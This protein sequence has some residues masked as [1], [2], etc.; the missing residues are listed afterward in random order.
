MNYH[1]EYIHWKNQ[2]TVLANRFN[3]HQDYKVKEFIGKYA[4]DIRILRKYKDQLP[5]FNITTDQKLDEDTM[6]EFKDYV[7]W[8]EV[9]R[10]QILSEKFIEEFKDKMMSLKFWHFISK[11]QTLSEKF[12]IEHKDELDW[13]YISSNQDFSEAFAERFIEKID[14]WRYFGHHSCCDWKTVGVGFIKKHLNDKF[15]DVEILKSITWA[16][17]VHQEFDDALNKLKKELGI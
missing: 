8:K 7:D 13:A 10:Q 2:D 15:K 12:I 3:N 4:L 5:W 14:W 1:L 17:P 11:F 16:F 6:R 9:P